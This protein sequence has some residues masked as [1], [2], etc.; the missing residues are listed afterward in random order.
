MHPGQSRA[1][2]LFKPYNFPP[3][4]AAEYLTKTRNRH[5][6]GFIVSHDNVVPVE[7]T[8]YEYLY[9]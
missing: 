3:L 1:L 5:T 6:Y 7:T 8:R 4:D 2:R 9:I